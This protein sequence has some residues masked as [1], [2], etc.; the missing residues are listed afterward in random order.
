M[1]IREDVPFTT[2]YLTHAFEFEK[3]S[4]IWR[5]AYNKTQEQLTALRQKKN[6]LSNQYQALNGRIQ[7]F[8]LSAENNF[9][10]QM[11][12]IKKFKILSIVCFSI[13]PLIA[14]FF[15][16]IML[17]SKAA[18]TELDISV[19]ES[20][21][22]SVFMAFS[23]SFFPLLG[24]IIFLVIYRRKKKKI[25]SK[26]VFMEQ[27]AYQK[28]S[29]INQQSQSKSEFNQLLIM[30]K[31]ILSDQNEIETQYNKAQAVLNEIYAQEDWPEKYRGFVPVGTMLEYLQMKRCTYITGHGG[32]IDTYELDLRHKQ[33]LGT[34]NEIRQISLQ[35]LAVQ[36]QMLQYQHLI[37]NELESINHHVAQI[38]RDVQKNIEINEDIR[39]N[40]EIQTTAT[41]QSARYQEYLAFKEW[42]RN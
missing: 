33:I 31:N 26:P 35:S 36:Q 28:Q 16:A 4:E 14:L 13:I 1:P 20:I 21:I 5:E 7:N 8:D 22:M 18:D 10:N 23:M 34:L 15:I 32:M 9:H 29:L 42:G 41:Q 2:A 12:A 40:Q 39:K 25:M 19:L 24:G 11:K 27:A 17:L 37:L 38:E 6:A 30:E 3:Y